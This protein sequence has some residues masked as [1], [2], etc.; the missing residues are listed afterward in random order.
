MAT[1]DSPLEALAFQYASFGVLAV[2]NNVWTWIAVVTAAVSFWRMKVT[3]IGDNGDH[4]CSL[5]E[6]VTTSKAEQEA[7][8]QEP[9]EMADPVEEAAAPPANETKVWEPLMCD[10]GVTK[11]KLTMC[12]EVDVDGGRY[13]DTEEELTAVNYYGG[14]FGNSGEWWERW[15]RVVR[16]RN[17]DDEWYRYVDL[18]VI[19]GSVVRLWDDKRNPLNRS[20]CLG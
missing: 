11:G 6:D 3:T 14:G 16:M 8:H 10:D 4:G 15:E 20:R 17:G 13:V 7:D 18:T 1:L 5:L 2:V 19:N 9:Q 12:Y